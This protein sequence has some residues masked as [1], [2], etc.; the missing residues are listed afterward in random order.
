M[1][2]WVAQNNGVFISAEE[3]YFRKGPYWY[4]DSDSVTVYEVQMLDKSDE[5]TKTVYFAFGPFNHM[6]VTVQE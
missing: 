3:C 2:N 4:T 5:R 1:E 6:D